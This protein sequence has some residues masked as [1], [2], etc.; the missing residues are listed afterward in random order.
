MI[1][2]AASPTPKP[3]QPHQRTV[4]TAEVEASRRDKDAARGT[5]PA[6]LAS[7]E[8]LPASRAAANVLGGKLMTPSFTLYQRL[9]RCQLRSTPPGGRGSATSPILRP[10]R[11][12]ACK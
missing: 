4:C 7:D 3:P 8:P 9:S 12:V 2:P 5:A 1:A 10:A 6:E 11:V